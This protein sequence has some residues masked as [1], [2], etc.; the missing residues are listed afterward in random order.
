MTS[1]LD[2]LIQADQRLFLALNGWHSPWADHLMNLVTYK[3]T[4]T[5]L[6]LYLLY[7]LFRQLGRQAVGV[8][9]ALLVAVGLAD[10][11]A[12]GLFKPYFARLRPCHDP[13]LSTLVHV[14]DGCG[15]QF[16]F[17]SSHA[18]TAFALA[19]AFGSLVGPAYR[20]WRWLLVWAVVYSFSRIYVGVHYPADLLGGALVGILCG[21]ACAALFKN[22]FRREIV[23]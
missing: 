13:A 1:T 18:A 23:I 12:S 6:Y 21:A 15:G 10:W 11:V 9:L 3:Y 14:V 4:W 17:V 19:T 8:V 7:S 16:G 22:V 5:P 20:G 2:T